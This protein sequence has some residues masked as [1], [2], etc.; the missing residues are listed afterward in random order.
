[1][2]TTTKKPKAPVL[3]CRRCGSRAIR[4]SES[5]QMRG[6]TGRRRLHADVRCAKCRHRWWS[7]SKD[8]LRQSREADRLAATRGAPT[9][10]EGDE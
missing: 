5:Q 1:M 7:V 10:S 6:K 8:A 3:A 4:V 9:T 2:P